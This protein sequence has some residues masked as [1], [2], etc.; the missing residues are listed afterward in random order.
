M[1]EKTFLAHD[2]VCNHTAYR[3]TPVFL[4]W[5]L[6]R[7]IR[8]QALLHPEVKKWHRCNTDTDVNS[9]RR[10]CTS[11]KAFFQQLS[12]KLADKCPRRSKTP[13][14]CLMRSYFGPK[15]ACEVKDAADWQYPPQPA[16]RINSNSIFFC[17]SVLLFHSFAE[18]LWSVKAGSQ[19]CWQRWQRLVS[20]VTKPSCEIPSLSLGTNAKLV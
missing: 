19:N 18:Q 4:Y 16:R 2:N 17:L 3:F 6:M 10:S 1:S 11:I 9:T 14:T 12:L 7:Q 5:V 8:R 15:M 20:V 13:V